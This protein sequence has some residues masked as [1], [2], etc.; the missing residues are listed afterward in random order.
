MYVLSSETEKKE[1]M[2]EVS[3]DDECRGDRRKL[4]ERREK[5]GMAGK[6]K[7]YVIDK[8]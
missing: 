6:K 5:D 4:R 7:E 1:L 8:M 2:K 3:R